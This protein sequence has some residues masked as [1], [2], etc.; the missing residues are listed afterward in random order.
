[1][2]GFLIRRLFWAAVVVL[3]TALL[4][5]GGLR[6]LRPEIFPGE[7]WLG[8]VRGDLQRVL[9][10][11]DF[12]HATFLAAQSPINGL[13][14][15]GIVVDVLF[16]AGTFVIGVTLGVSAGLWCASRP[17]SRT[18]RALEWLAMFFFCTPVYVVGLTLLLLFA[19]PFGIWEFEPLFELHQY[20][21]PWEDPW[22]FARAMLVPYLVTAAPLAAVCL[23][24]T[25][26][27]TIEVLDEDYVRTARAKGLSHREAVR[28][29][30]G[31]SA[32]TPVAALMSVSMPV[33]VTNMVLTEIVFNVPG[34]F[35]Y[36]KKAIEGIEPPGPVPDYNA[37]QVFAI[38]AACFIVVATVLADFVLARLDPRIRTSD[39]PWG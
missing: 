23:R 12:G 9:I 31:R 27:S 36:F 10:D 1:M 7:P 28:H 29:H 8:G 4:A 26:A 24:L 14:N 25:L 34:V 22:T 15:R 13:V 19:P 35:R 33:V 5:F 3:A 39:R 18:A 17:R 32:Y 37:L 2:L 11:Q 38:Y 30:A 6:A 16:L 20:I 21:A